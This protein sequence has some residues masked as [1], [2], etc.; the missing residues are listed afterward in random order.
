MDVHKSLLR[1][2]LNNFSFAAVR[3]EVT[4]FQ[5]YCASQNS[6]FAMDPELIA[7]QLQAWALETA[8]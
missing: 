4:Q 5:L 7:L 3:K 2:Y 6:L 8:V 1:V